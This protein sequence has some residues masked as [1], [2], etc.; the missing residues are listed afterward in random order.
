MHVLSMVVQWP[1]DGKT[2]LAAQYL[3]ELD[4]FAHVATESP[5][6]VDAGRQTDANRV[7]A[8]HMPEDTQYLH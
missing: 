4:A 1:S 6:H 5:A 2:L 8:T 3:H 7:V